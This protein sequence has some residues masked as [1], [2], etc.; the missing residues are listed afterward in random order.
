MNK[1]A[2]TLTV[3]ELRAVIAEEVA[4]VLADRATTSA[5]P[6]WLGPDAAAE[7]I[8]VIPRTLARMVQRKEI[9]AS[10]VGRKLRFRRSDLDAYLASTRRA[11]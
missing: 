11:A 2:F 6:D 5:P 7:I 1:P 8:G 10:R 4:R 9:P 3:D